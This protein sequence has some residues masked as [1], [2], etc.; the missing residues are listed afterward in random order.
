MK[1]AG[2]FF[3]DGQ[4]W[5]EQRHFVVRHLRDLGMG[6]KLLETMVA[7]EYSLFAER[8]KKRVGQE[9]KANDLFI[10][11]VLNI[12]WK[13]VADER[14]DY[15]DPKLKQLQTIVTDITKIVSPQNILTWFPSARFIAPESSGFNKLKSYKVEMTDM[16]ERRFAEHKASLD[17][18]NPRDLIDAFLIEMQRPG[19]AERGFDKINLLTNVLD[20][21]TAGSE[22]TATSLTWAILLM[23]LYPDMQTKMQKE[24]DE[25][26]GEDQIPSYEDR[27]RLPYTEAVMTEV[28]RFGSFVPVAVPHFANN[29]PAQLAGYTIPQGSIVMLHLYSAHH[30]RAHW[31]DPE[32]FRPE[33]F[34]GDNGKFRND[35]FFMQFSLGKR[36]CPGESMARTEFFT[37]LACLFHQFHLR[38]PKG[39]RRPTTEVKEF[40]I[41][42]QPEEFNVIFEQIREE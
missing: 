2:M 37:F 31:D 41:F 16:V 35:D 36:S 23:V 15:D 6:K 42:L 18:N 4:L 14:F 28:W 5:H 40:A 17:P 38:L 8:I 32:V 3:T 33:R 34:L 26:M 25:V 39:A 12:I 13:M 29:G 22:T 7:D 20:L 11:I 9:V 1:R 19:A 30:D 21:F 24:L 10:T 27:S